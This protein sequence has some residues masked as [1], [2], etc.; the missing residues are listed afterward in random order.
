VPIQAIAPRQTHDITS[1]SNNYRRH[2]ILNPANTRDNIDMG[3]SLQE[4]LDATYALQP[5]EAR[6]AANEEDWKKRTVRLYF[7]NVNGLRLRDSGSDILETFMQLNEI[8]ADIF[9]IVE[10]KLNCQS[11]DVREVIQN[12]KRKVWPHGKIFTSSSDEE[13]SHTSKP[14]GT[15]LGVTGTLVGRV[16]KHNADKYGRWVQVDLLGRMGRTIS[17]ICAYQVVQESGIQGDRTTYSQQVRMMRLEGIEKPDP[18]KQF[19]QDLKI[20]VKTLHDADHDIILMGDFNESIGVNPAGMA[21]VMTKGELTDAFCH[22]HSLLQEK[23][24]YARGSKRVDYILLSS[25]VLNYVSKTGAE[26]F[27]FRIFSDHRGLFVDFSLPGFFDRAPNLLVPAKSRDLIYD[28]PRHVRK[29]LLFMAT[30]LKDHNIE[31][32][33]QE[34]L[35]G[36]RNDTAAEAIDRDITKGML[37]AEATCKS[38]NRAPWSKALH[39][40]MNRLYI[41]KRALSQWLTGLDMSVAI[42]MRQAKL[43]SPV[44]I[45]NTLPDL[46]TALREA[47]KHRREVLRSG[48]EHRQTYQQDRILALQM[49]NPKKAPATIEKAFYSSIA[50]KELFRR[51]PSA[52]PVTSSGISMIKVPLIPT[53]DPKAKDTVFRSVVDP[54]EVERFILERNRKH[55]SQARD[56]PLATATITNLI[57][58]GGTTSVADKLLKGTETIRT[59]TTNPSGRAILEQCRRINP[60]QP[61]GISLEEFKDSFRKWR[62]GTSTSPS[63]RHLSHQ[64]T[65]FQPH[66]IDELVEPKEHEQAEKSRDA[67]WYVQHAI[68]SYGIEHGYSF[69]RWKQVVNAMIE[70]EPGNP[71]LHRLRVIHLYESDYNALLGIKMRQVVHRAEDTNSLHRGTYGSRANRQATDPTFLE[72][73]QYDYASLTRWPEIK[74]SNDATSCYDRIIP[75][76]SNVIARSMGLHKNIAKIHGS[77]LEHAVYRIKTQLGISTDSY[78]HSDGSPVFGTGQGS[79]ASP[80][81]WLLNCSAYFTIYESKCYGA[82]YVNMDGSKTVKLGMTG[83]VDDN[84]CNVNSRPEDEATLCLH[85]THDAQLWNDILWG[86]GGELEHSKC[87]YKYLHTDFTPSG[88]PYFRGGQF[89]T[90]IVIEDATGHRTQLEHSSAYQAYKTLGTY[91]AATK[92]QKTQFEMLQKK[93]GSLV[94][95]LALSS[96]SANAAWLYYSSIFMKGIGY[97]LA[98]SRLSKTQLHQLQAPMTSLTLNRLGYPRSTSRTVVFGSRFFGGLEFASLATTQ[99]AGK[100]TLLLRHLRTPGD[101][102]DFAMIVLDRLQYNAGVGY[103]I[104]EYPKE[105]IPHLEGIWMPTVREYLAEIDG[106]LQT[107]NTNIQ[108]LQR[109]SDKYIME[110]VLKSRLFQP[111]EIKYVN[112]CRLYLQVVTL[113]DIYNAQGT[114]FAVGI[115]DGYKSAS[116]SHSLLLEPLQERPNAQT[117]TLWRRFLRSLSPDK[118]H[119]YDNL[120]PWFRGLSSRRRWPCYYSPSCDMIYRLSCSE[121]IPHRRINTTSFSENRSFFG[122]CI[123]PIDSIPVDITD[124]DVGWYMFQTTNPSNPP[125]EPNAFPSFSEYL[126]SLPDHEC[127]L[128]Q[129]YEIL[130]DDVYDLC[131]NLQNIS[132]IVLV[133]DGGAAFDCGSYGWVMCNQDGTRL[134]RGSGSVFGFDPR[135]YR[136]EGHGAKAG[137]LFLVHCFLYCQQPLPTGQFKFYCDNEGLLKKLEYLRSYKHAIYATCLHSEWD[138]VSSVHRLQSLFRPPPELIHVKGHQDDSMHYDFLELQE[139]LNVDAD[140]LA[141]EELHEYSSIKSLVPFDPASG[142]QLNIA[143]KTVTRQLGTAIHNQHHLGPLRDYYSTRFQWSLETFEN[144]DWAHYAMAYKRFPRHRTFYSKFGWKKL[145]I[146]KRLHQRT[147]SYDHRCPSC[148]HDFED[149]D[150]VFQCEHLPRS[151]WRTKLL[152]SINGSVGEFLDPDLLA[153]I[154]IGIRSYFADSMPDFSERFPD[155]YS[156]TPYYDL[157]EQQNS[158]GWDHFI[159]GKL[160]KE[161]DSVQYRYSARYGLKKVSEGWTLTLIKLLANSSFQLWEIRNQCRHGHDDA[162]KQQIIHDQVHRE[163]RCLYILR[164]QTLDQDRPLFCSTVDEHLSQTTPQLQSWILHNRKLILHSVKVAKAQAKIHTHRIQEFFPQTGT[165]RSL[166]TSAPT[167]RICRHR[168][169]RMSQFFGSRPSTV[170][171]RGPS[172]P[173]TPIIFQAQALTTFFSVLGISRSVLP[174]VAEDTTLISSAVQR[175]QLRRR[176][177]NI[178]DLFPDHPG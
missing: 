174:T 106:S 51:V 152:D 68:V 76:V 122:P 170:S 74:F 154:R 149:D 85:A 67:N 35:Q 25:R 133:S 166:A 167:R 69:Q 120:G 123:L 11:M 177:L 93:A 77:M 142:A 172:Q 52:R 171:R 96:C 107:A 59:I 3:D 159:R 36:P 10:T 66:G 32:R 1:V 78:T 119:V 47:Q 43:E 117:W 112:Y 14:G 121:Y 89:G 44:P 99:G 2:A 144:I 4:I 143:G 100:I 62:V 56:T 98:V 38:T 42:S 49:A 109:Q 161:W 80:P 158:I 79:T 168:T 105:A 34:L 13:W 97:P 101:P 164:P 17:I 7:Q 140:K 147:A 111:R 116:Q 113:S 33:L 45:P 40:A 137:I 115:Y 46:K 124:I 138:I 118:C 134:A 20:L 141:T 37:A 132:E 75:S 58:F 91:Q 87:S 173:P 6:A 31:D 86:S 30:Y 53:A 135:S 88:I 15:M 127:L 108:P 18:R 148:S 102:R 81:F 26:P 104:L 175:R 131:T 126:Q 94:R 150:H 29:Y 5:E 70:K 21:S 28:C 22:R 151:I 129:R 54:L 50:S 12:C 125:D 55:F 61:A 162:T 157:I 146:A 73:L 103:P 145:P 60:V 160:T 169:T 8:Q 176:A 114:A 163:I 128:L 139:Q 64:H 178:P 83:F 19:I 95:T 153:I 165:A 71:Q 27:N 16:K 65:L 110:E 136:A 48:K 39:E 23:P 41:L 130:C 90:P 63:G 84:T 156:S 57:G 72:V 92:R 24:T 155:G 9:G 82:R